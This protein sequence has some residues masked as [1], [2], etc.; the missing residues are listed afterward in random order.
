MGVS[1]SRE[2]TFGVV[3]GFLEGVL[4]GFP[5]EEGRVFLVGFPFWVRYFRGVSIK[6]FFGGRGFFSGVLFEG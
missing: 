5:L 4:E 2:V 1:Y 3:R 6:V